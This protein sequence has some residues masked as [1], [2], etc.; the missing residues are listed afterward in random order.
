MFNEADSPLPN[1]PE[2][3]T[4]IPDPASTPT[5]HP[6]PLSDSLLLSAVAAGTHDAEQI[7]ARFN[8]RLD[9]FLDWLSAPQTVAR[10]NA[11]SAARANVRL[12]K[13][14]AMHDA[15]L[16]TLEEL[17]TSAAQNNDPVERRRAA[18][19]I[20][21]FCSAGMSGGGGGARSDRGRLWGSGGGAAVSSATGDPASL[22]A[23]ISLSRFPRH[24]RS[25]SRTIRTAPILHEPPVILPPPIEP[26]RSASPVQITTIL[27]LR[28]QDSDNPAPGDGLRSLYHAFTDSWRESVGA[29]SADEFACTFYEAYH[30]LIAHHSAVQLSTTYPPLPEGALP[31]TPPTTASQLFQFIDLDGLLR[32]CIFRFLR[33]SAAHPWLIDDVV[34]PIIEPDEDTAAAAM[35]EYALQPHEQIFRPS[36]LAAPANSS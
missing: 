35:S 14:Q 2:P 17:H 24:Y 21:R 3:E 13:Q 31:G 23:G 9:L 29:R 16:A 1:S 10:L 34:F 33:A 28:L 6:I 19:A 26:G 30:L 15:A 32:T 7:A 20:V 22:R 8:I 11:L 12:Q 25:R 27:L 18:T 36:S 5:P 4:R